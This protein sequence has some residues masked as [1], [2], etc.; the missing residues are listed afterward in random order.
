MQFSGLMTA[1]GT[2]GQVDEIAEDAVA[3]CVMGNLAQSLVLIR[4]HS[5]DVEDQRSFR[6]G[7]HHAIQGR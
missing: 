2:R 1:R 7:A 4:R 3:K 5:D 6:L